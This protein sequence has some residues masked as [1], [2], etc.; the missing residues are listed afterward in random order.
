MAAG[1]ILVIIATLM[2]TFAPRGQIGTFIAG[3]VIIGIGQGLALTAGSIYIGELSPPEIR[4]KIM[5]FWQ[6]FYSV[7]S[8]IAYWV[9]FATSKHPKGLGEWDWKMVVIFQ[10][11]VPILIL[12]QVF[13][14]PE[15]SKHPRAK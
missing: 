7:G 9:S 12:S 5:S 11:L 8:F 6:M 3:R 13:F 10:L 15:V 14:I 4:G 1:A 2:Q